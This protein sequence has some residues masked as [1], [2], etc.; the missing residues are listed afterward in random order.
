ME[1]ID[2]NEGFGGRLTHSLLVGSLV[3]EGDSLQAE[4]RF[5]SQLIHFS[6]P[7]PMIA[8]VIPKGITSSDRYF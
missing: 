7:W 3:F 8:E 5:I 4:D 1:F 6:S 2:S